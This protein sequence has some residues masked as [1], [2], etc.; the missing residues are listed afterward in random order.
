MPVEKIFRENPC[1]S[2]IDAELTSVEK[3]IVILNRTVAYP[4]SGGQQSDSGTI[5]VFE[6]LSADKNG[7]EIYYTIPDYHALKAGDLVQVKI[8]WLKR[9]RI[10]RLHLAAELVLELVYTEFGRPEKTGVN[11][12]FEKARVDFLWKG[13]IS[14][15]FP[16]LERRIKHLVD[17]NLEISSRFS[18]IGNETRYWEIPGFAK[19]PCGGKHLRKTGEVGNIILKRVNPRKGS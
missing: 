16:L 7:M 13:N 3:S 17:S 18:N 8:D 12:T 2:E 11:I 6:I 14:E 1:L 4:F 9:Y 19:V 15:T 5:G 10:M